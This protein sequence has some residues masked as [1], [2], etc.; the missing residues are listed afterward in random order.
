MLTLYFSGTGNSRYV[1]ERFSSLMQADCHSIEGDLD[2]DKLL[3]GNDTLCFCY[4]IYG[5]CVPR[6][7]REFVSA[8]QSSLQDKKLVLFCTQLLFSGDGARVFTDLLVGIRY[9]V[10]QAEHIRMPNNLCNAFPFPVKDADQCKKVFDAADRMLLSAAARIRA[11]TIRKRGFNPFSKVLGFLTQRFFFQ[12]IETIAKST[13]R[14]SAN[15]NACGAC[16]RRCP[17]GNLRLATDQ[18]GQRHVVQNGNCTICY[19]CVNICPSQAITV[20]L[21]KKVTHQYHGPVQ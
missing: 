9:Q 16:V 13:V 4:P 11:G 3:E 1:A 10:I 20:M 12:K 15:C 8:H 5:S 14:V 7:L 6:I 19:R 2:F 17:M 21:H 18:H